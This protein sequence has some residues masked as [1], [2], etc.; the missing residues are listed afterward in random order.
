MGERGAYI[1][2]LVEQYRLIAAAGNQASQH[3]Y[4][5]LQWGTA[6]VGLLAGAAISQWA[7]SDGVVEFSF[8]LAIPTL[9]AAGM[10]FWL[11]ELARI[12]RLADFLCALETKLDLALTHPDGEEAGEW[13]RSF[14]REWAERGDEVLARAHVRPPQGADGIAGFGPGPIT[15]ERWLREIRALKAAKNLAW[16]Y[17][18]R[19]LLFPGV[20]ASAWVV[21]AFY[22]LLR[23]GA[24]PL[25]WEAVL[26]LIL[27]LLIIFSATWLAAEIVRT[28][29]NPD[30]AASPR[31][32]RL[33][34][35]RRVAGLLEM[36]E[37]Q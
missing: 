21:G 16:V 8:L 1:E 22:A 35:L 25:R 30:S 19:L 14:S 17:L 23:S 26:T 6:V 29:R 11:G 18:F 32:A 9:A 13:I 2:L 7:K 33:W 4:T 3:A 15:F 10:L 12:D 36:S 28:F 5:A 37:W 34:L 31:G 20:M 24:P 27:G